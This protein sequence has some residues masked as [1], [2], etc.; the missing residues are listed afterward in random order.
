MRSIAAAGVALYI[1]TLGAIEST[2]PLPGV[3]LFYTDTGG[4][5]VPIVLMHA[6]TGS[7]R[8]WEHQTSAFVQAG[9]RVVAFDRRGW[10]RTTSEPGTAPGTAADDLIALMDYLH[11]DRFHLVGTAAG[12]FV[13]FD[14]ALSFPARLRS[15]VV[16]NS[17][18]GVQDESFV[19]LGRRLRPPEFSA[20]PRSCARCRR[21]TA[22]GILKA[23]RGGWS[24][25]RSAGRRVRRP[26]R[27]RS[28]TG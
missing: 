25:R 26:P 17:I 14:A 28:R 7:V 20:M 10:G 8:A 6:A 19:E 21:R 4:A 16:A 13:T 18:G 1:L 24:W 3:K 15:I 2:A 23:R 11:I 22:R 5:G 9:Y 12:G 27:N